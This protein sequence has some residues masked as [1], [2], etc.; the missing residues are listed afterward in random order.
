MAT[1]ADTELIT[2]QQVA[3]ELMVHPKTVN[4]WLRAGELEGVRAG[5]LWRISRSALDRYLRRHQEKA[6]P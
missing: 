3:D 6:L 1:P 2:T 5:R 4:N